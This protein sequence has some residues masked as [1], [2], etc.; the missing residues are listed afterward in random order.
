[1]SVIVIAKL[2]LGDTAAP[3]GGCPV[4]KLDQFLPWNW[5]ATPAKLAA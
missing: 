2:G 3:L 4:R 1:M 5:K